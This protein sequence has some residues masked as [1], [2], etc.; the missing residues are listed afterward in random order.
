MK[1]QDKYHHYQ[2]GY[3]ARGVCGPRLSKGAMYI[4]VFDFVP[5]VRFYGLP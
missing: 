1:H 3:G 2:S 5:H 4:V